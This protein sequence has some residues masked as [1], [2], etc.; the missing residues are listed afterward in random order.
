MRKLTYFVAQTADGF[1]CGPD[2]SFDFF[3]LAPDVTK[4]AA[5]EYPETVPTHVR[6]T[7]GITAANRHFDTLLQGRISYQIALDEGIT[8]PYAHMRQYVPS[9]T[10]E[11]SPDPA[12][13]IVRDDPRELVR[14]L[15][16]EEGDL[17][18][19]LIGGA[20]L[21]GALLPEIDEML[22]KRYPVV[23]GAG[24]PVFAGEF[25]PAPLKRVHTRGFNSG[26]DFTLY[27]RA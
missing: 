8:S 5:R 20:H 26:A 22:V 27:R 21:A 11:H 16:R 18:I 4:Y 14:S 6:G 13:R 7:F 19:C 3:P 1:I 2:G 23:A 15:K 17:G 25:A 24:L 12:V 10:I 9:R